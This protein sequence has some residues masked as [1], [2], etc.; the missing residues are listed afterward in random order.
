[1]SRFAPGTPDGP[2]VGSFVSI[3][4]GADDVSFDGL[5]DVNFGV[6]VQSLAA[7]PEPGTFPLLLLGLVGLLFAQARTRN[8]SSIAQCAA[9]FPS[10]AHLHFSQQIST[11]TVSRVLGKVAVTGQTAFRETT[12]VALLRLGLDVMIS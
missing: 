3:Q 8:K 9:G 1:M 7:V 4:D 10:V 5:A 6:N 12:L 2:Y 11:W